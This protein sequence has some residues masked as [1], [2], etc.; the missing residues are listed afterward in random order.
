LSEVLVWANAGGFA[1]ADGWFAEHVDTMESQKPSVPA[2][3][4]P[5]GLLSDP[6]RWVD[7]HG[8][9]L[10]AFAL[11][12]LRDPQKAEDAVQETF[13]AAL[14][15]GQHFAG[16]SAERSWLTGILKNKIYDHF[17]KASRETS[18]TDLQFYDDEEGD[19][20]VADGPGQGGWIHELGPQEWPKAG[21]SLDNELFWKTYRE[22]ADKLP[23]NVAAVFNLREVDGMESR[24]ICDL[25]NISDSNLWVMLHRARMALRRCQETNWFAKNK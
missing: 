22:C 9:Y 4:K 8:D 21:E 23:K 1:C 5:G 7:E 18:F 10:F 13:L 24:E 17:R 11:T 19:R 20:F 6:E 3:A 16:R 15:G 2:E 12:R 14:R 25:L